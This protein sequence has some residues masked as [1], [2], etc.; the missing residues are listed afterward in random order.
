MGLMTGAP[1][2]ATVVAASDAECYRLDKA[3]F[4]DIIHARQSIAESMSQILAQRQHAYGDAQEAF[5]KERHEP[6]AHHT[7]IL[8]RMRSFFGLK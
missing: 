1:R 3:G 8:Q 5:R 4:E 7:D 6:A 2:A